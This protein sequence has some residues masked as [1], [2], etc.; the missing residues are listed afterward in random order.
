MW[1]CSRLNQIKKKWQVEQYLW[2]VF[3]KFKFKGP[4]E[5]GKTALALAIS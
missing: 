1:N 5:T 4:P 2:Q 3:Y